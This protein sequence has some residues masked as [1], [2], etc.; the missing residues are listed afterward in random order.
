MIKF[1]RHIFSVFAAFAVAFLLEGCMERMEEIYLPTD[2]VSFKASLGNAGKSLAT[3]G[4]S[5]DLLDFQEEEWTLE[6]DSY[7]ATRATLLTSLDKLEAGV[8]GYVYSGSWNAE[9]CTPL[10]LM[11][12]ASYTFDNDQLDAASPV[13]WSTVE[14]ESGAGTGNK[15][16]AF[17]YAPKGDVTPTYQTP[18]AGAN[19]AKGAPVI[20][21]DNVL[22]NQKDIIVADKEVVIDMSET[23]SHRKEVQLDFE[24]IYTAIQFKAGFACTINSISITGIATAGE[25]VIGKGWE[26]N[27]ETGSYNLEIPGG[28][29]V[30]QGEVLGDIILMIP[31]TIINDAQI[32]LTYNGSTT[33]TASLKGVEWKQGK[34]ITYTLMNSKP[35]IYFDLAAEN[36]IIKGTRY[37]G[38][39]YAGGD[40]V[41]VKGEIEPGQKYYVYQSCVTET[42]KDKGNYKVGY[43]SRNSETK[44]PEG[45]FTKPSYEPVKY[46]GKLWSDYI[47][48]NTS[49]EDVIEAWDNADGAGRAFKHN[50][51]DPSV[52]ANKPENI[53]AN[54]S[55]AK[56]AV[57]SVGREATKHRIHV[58]GNVGNCLMVIDNIYSSYHHIAVGRNKGG[59]AFLPGENS[60]LTINIVG[61][62]RV[63]CVHYSN[64]D[65]ANNNTLIFDGQGS[66][67]VASADFYTDTHNGTD[68]PGVEEMNDTTYFANH[69]CSAIGNNDSAD[70]CYGIIIKGGVIF[71]GTTKAENCTAIGGGGNGYG[72]V[73]IKGGTVTAVATTT[74]TAIGGGIGYNSKGGEG[75]VTIEGGNVYAYN[76]G[77]RWGI[78]SSAIGGAGSRKSA[79]NTGTVTIKGGNIYALSEL[80]TAIG[81]GSSSMM[82]GG[83]GIVKILGGSVI[84]KTLDPS[85]AGIGGGSSYKEKFTKTDNDSN[86]TVNGGDAEI[87]IS[88][89]AV[90]R[91]GSI[92]GGAPGKGMAEGGK[93][94]SAKINVSGGDI[95]AQFVMANSP[96]NVFNMT[97]GL[98][99]NS[100]TSDNEY[101]CI[102]S[103]GAAVYME[104]GKFTM[105]N[106][107]IRNCYADKYST[108]KGGAVYIEGGNFVMTGGEIK[109]CRANADGGAV[110]LQGG[111]VSIEGGTIDA[112]V[113]YD[114]N[115]GAV[116]VMG[117]N[118]TME[119]T[120]SITQNAAFNK[121]TGGVNGNGGGIYV[122]PQGSS[123]STINVKLDKGS[124]TSNSADRFGGGVCVDMGK[125]DSAA[126]NVIVGAESEGL[127]T[128][129]P[130]ISGN[131]ALTKGGGM[132]V[133][134]SNA[135]VLLYDGNVLDNGTS[136]YQVNPDMS[137]EGGGLVTL[138]KAGITTQVTVTFSNNA[139]Y[140]T[141]GATA[142]I[143]KQ[144]FIVAAANSKLDA[145]AF[146][147]INDYY[148]TFKGW[149]TKRDG[150]GK[151]YTD[152]DAVALNESVVL[153]AQ[154]E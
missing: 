12:G 54:G 65:P 4:G 106:G 94:G 75:K 114:G 135:S 142:D 117:G 50:I 9:S 22:E 93:I 78:P 81:G 100:R 89:N 90:V 134:G 31:Q 74:G 154:W 87:E 61:D 3:R 85:S 128:S 145:N 13:K 118:F 98:I 5:I 141:Q 71:A 1:Y 101:Y 38:A 30:V 55:G 35:Y 115:G 103:K 56:G 40:T 69:W 33:V 80:G 148:N 120:G 122:A 46:D 79:G 47:T 96:N 39:V 125:N 149:N 73:T 110:Y 124:I 57:R 91:T 112:N 15:F 151:S 82:Y 136:S 2:Y 49:V 66:L 127:V 97:G 140:Y 84:A 62:N 147:A 132:Y 123:S 23:K 60:S 88:G 86:F 32:S 25:Y 11:S 130:L 72:E 138:K 116:C 92:G 109:E 111:K 43:S 99:R 108:D 48:N 76:Y 152:E 102:Q 44:K 26:L 52:N 7:G 53:V 8:Y 105:S 121:T 137:V 10:D 18:A 51:E 139:Q 21:I 144:Q 126:L 28:K 63:G 119:G 41:H 150:T 107:E 143:T 68:Y 59:I 131:S 6:A 20:K 64:T 113:A 17:V 37:S 95:Q 16:R 27:G 146:G 24:H 14:S 19:S 29:S 67:T 77:N 45:T 83:K 36:V 129:N 133:N 58:T 153:Y 34:K 42:N 104:Q 70:K